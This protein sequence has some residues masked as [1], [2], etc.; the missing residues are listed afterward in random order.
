MNPLN[1]ISLD[2]VG[3]T[4]IYLKHLPSREDEGWTLVTARYQEAGRGAGD[5]SWE[6]EAGQNL[7][8]SL[9]THPRLR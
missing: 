5:N 3:S 2:T 1:I 4:N 8:F 7:L 6:S 9:R